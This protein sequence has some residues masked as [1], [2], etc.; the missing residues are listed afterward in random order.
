M[1]D[2]ALDELFTRNQH[3]PI[4]GAGRWTYK[5]NS[6]FNPG[7]I[8]YKGNVLLV[9]RVEARTGYSHLTVATSIDGQTEWDIDPSPTLEAE[10][11]YNEAK[12][13]LEDARVV[14]V[15]EL[16]KYLI[17]CTSFMAGGWDQA[18]FGISLIGTKDFKTFERVSRCLLPDDKDGALFPRRINGK[19][20]LI[21]RPFVRGKGHIWCSVSPDLVHWGKSR[22]LL[23]VGQWTW[24]DG[25]IGI[26]PPP[27]ETE[28]GWLL[29]YHGVR[30]TGGGDIYRIGLALLDIDTL[31]VI[32]RSAE[33]IFR[34][35]ADYEVK[36]DVGRVV[37]PCGAVVR[38]DT[39]F[40]YYGGAD[41]CVCLATSKMPD[42][43]AYLRQCPEC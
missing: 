27:I 16:D 22:A 3:N 6:A 18:P 1:P 35:H 23:K 10:A 30:N 32:R 39:L 19:W 15:S 33:W 5:I 13:G 36:G 9:V 7:A 2:S 8:L 43:L 25:R 42:I 38:E 4:L 17:T 26:G 29:I 40:M 20:V 37:F 34:P 11:K 31:E 28:E 12:P 24:D 21:H 41:T 14:F